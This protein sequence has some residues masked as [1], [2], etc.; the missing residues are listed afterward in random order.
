[1][2]PSKPS[3]SSPDDAGPSSSEHDASDLRE[4]GHYVVTSHPPGSVVTSVRCNF[5][6][7]SSNDVVVAKSNRL[8]VRTVPSPGALSGADG[9]SGEALPVSLSL[10]I[11]GR[12]STLSPLRFANEDVDC[13]FLT[14]ERGDYALIS[15]DAALASE[16]AAGRGGG[17]DNSDGLGAGTDVTGEQYPVATHASGT[18]RN[19]DS[20]ALS[21][22]REAEVGPILAVDPLARCIAVHVYDGFATVI[23]V[24]RNYRLSDFTRLPYRRNAK[25]GGLG[26]KPR[27]LSTGPLG[28]AFHVRLEERTVLS[29]AFLLPPSGSKSSP[30]LPQLALLHQDVRGF[31]HAVSHGIDLQRRCL[32]PGGPVAGAT[33]GGGRFGAGGDVPRRP[34]GMPEEGEQLR[35]RMVDGGS[36]SIVAVPPRNNGTA[37]SG[38]GGDS[39][40]KKSAA[41]L[42]GGVLILGQ[43][44]ITYHSSAESNNTKILATGDSVILSCDVLSEGIGS[45]SR[46]KDGEE[47]VV[48]ARYLLGDDTG[49]IHLLSVIRSG[50][51]GNVS[52]LHLETLGYASLSSTLHYLGGGL[53]YVGSQ[54]GQSQLLRV[55][56]APSPVG[57]VSGGLDDPRGTGTGLEDTT[58]LS[59]V[60]EHDN[61]GPIVDFDLRPVGDV[62]S[63]PN[64]GGGRGRAGQSVVATCSGVAAEG[65]VR[66]VRNGVGMS[67]RAAVDM[68]GI[69]GMWGLRRSSKDGDDSFLVQS[70]VGETRVLGVQS[71][72]DLEVDGDDAMD[73]D[74]DEEEEE[75]GA[76][77]EVTIDGFDSTRSTLYAGNASVGRHDLLVQVVEDGVRLVDSATLACVAKWSPFGDADDDDEEEDGPSGFVT[78][79][80]ANESGQV[81]VA[82]RGGALVYLA[83]EE[84]AGGG[85]PSLRRV[86]KVTLDREVSC[87]DL[88]PFRPAKSDD[89]MDVDGGSAATVS[90]V[91]AVG[92]WDDFSVRL[93]SLADGTLDQLLRIDLGRSPGASAGTPSAMDDDDDATEEQGEGGGRHM[94][95]RS[96]RLVTMD[97][98]SSSGTSSTSYSPSQHGAGSV[99]MLLVGLGDGRLVS[100]VVDAPSSSSAGAQGWSVRSRKEVGLGT[101]GIGLV[102]FRHG[103]DGDGSAGGTC[104]LATGDR[105]TVVYLAGGGGVGSN[106]KLS[107]SAVSLTVDED[108]DEDDEESAGQAVRAASHRTVSVNAAC[109]FRS[110]LLFPPSSTRGSTLCTA[111]SAVLRLGSIDDIRKLHVANHKLGMTPRRIAHHEAGRVYAVGCIESGNGTYGIGAESNQRNVV[112]FFDDNTFEEV[113]RIELEAY[114]MIQTVRSASLSVNRSFDAGG[115]GGGGGDGAPLEYRPYVVLGTAYAF[116]DEDEPS[117]VSRTCLHAPFFHVFDS[118]G[119]FH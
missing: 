17:N 63:S 116:P 38:I 54:F 34:S 24:H 29:M 36:A 30:Y 67:E 92:L 87:L 84:G 33:R 96:L 16:L 18:F 26:G 43:R 42:L 80:S 70:F 119:G 111:D 58:Y 86:G 47:T 28:D 8:E 105:P 50:T 81:V 55:L 52:D 101:Q 79:A 74:E 19:A 103:R 113:S 35:K 110:S 48:A 117:M 69:K 27:G 57:T 61:L 3:P 91:V 12:I 93:L 32:V 99:D 1:M 25:G 90:P 11:N 44:Q 13:L 114:E 77:A 56:D 115:G 39:G 76:L 78:V 62:P 104:V 46:L 88:S 75:G 97:P 100:F 45:A 9:S 108:D 66:I 2:T 82:L 10:P 37:G 6:S 72:K 64:S 112:R 4:V 20:H 68:P 107:Y 65:S 31:Q 71:S 5:L 14:T 51:N 89:G 40:E 22:G 102:P 85:P 106:P 15:Y 7:S 60:E 94:M 95:A 73:D 59:L 23:P 83:V 98:R 109:P 21:G 118:L 53:V 41:D 49:R